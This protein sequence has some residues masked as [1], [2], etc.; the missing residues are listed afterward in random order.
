[1]ATFFSLS[2]IDL[3]R[4]ETRDSSVMVLTRLA[5]TLKFVAALLPST[6]TLSKLLPA[7][8]DDVILKAST[9]ASRHC[10]TPTEK[11]NSVNILGKC[12]LVFLFSSTL[13]SGGCFPLARVCYPTVD[14]FLDCLLLCDRQVAILKKDQYDN[15]YVCGGALIGP[16]H[17]LTA[18]HCIKG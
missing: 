8:A 2:I 7:L 6:A 15:V 4:P 3:N 12:S 16:S 9:V 10:L 1:M 11:L 17:V 5:A 18:A 13:L 14:R